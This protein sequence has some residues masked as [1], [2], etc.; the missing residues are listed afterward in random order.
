MSIRL[1]LGLWYSSVVAGTI[2]VFSLLVYSLVVQHQITEEHQEI[3]SRAGH[4]QAATQANAHLPLNS[5]DPVL[6]PINAFAAPG[7]YIQVVDPN[8]HLIVRSKNLGGQTLA[9]EP[10][11]LEA[12]RSGRDVLFTSR[13]GNDSVSVVVV[14]LVVDRQI[15]GYIEVGTAY[16][17]TSHTLADL[18]LILFGTGL[19]L[20]VVAGIIGWTIA[21]G[22]L[23]PIELITRTAEAIAQSRRPS[24]YLEGI[25]SRDELGRLSATINRMLTSLKDAYAAQQCYIEDAAHELRTPLTAIHANLELLGSHGDKLPAEERSEVVRACCDEADRMARLIDRVLT[26]AKADAGQVNFRP[27]QLDRL[28]V[29]VYEEARLRAKGRRIGLRQIDEVSLMADP[30][31]LRQLILIL[32]DNAIRYTPQ[33][34]TIT[35]S[36]SRDTTWAML[37][38]AD[39]GI[40]IS[41]E[42]LPHIFR[43]FYRGKQ[44]RSA[45]GTGLGL[46]IAKSIIEQHGGRIAVE[47]A[48]GKGSTF[49]AHLPLPSEQS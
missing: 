43:R 32:V 40:G 8:G 28:V 17:E 37:Q 10:H 21:G 7:I 49:T 46:A 23:K 30:D 44:T 47:S 45:P 36:L 42:D 22:T 34:R 27:T 19:L 13:V 16:R 20:T 35:L 26:L 39:S 14:P 48:P 1:R 25:D 5:Q 38:V 9:A 41:S 2:V 31:L 18:R 24:G 3:I 29:E 15:A 11:D 12:A 6:A 33:G 4:F